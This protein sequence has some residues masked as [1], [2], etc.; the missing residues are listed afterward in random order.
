MKN[1]FNILLILVIVSS[2]LL[3]ACGDGTSGKKDDG[4]IDIHFPEEVVLTAFN[5]LDD[6]YIEKI[7]EQEGVEEASLND[8]GS[9]SLKVTKEVQGQML[10]GMIPAIDAAIKELEEIKLASK[11]T[12]SDNYSKFEIVNPDGKEYFLENAESA[13]IGLDWIGQRVVT[14]QGYAA[15]EIGIEMTVKDEN[16]ELIDT[17]NY[18][19]DFQEQINSRI[20]MLEDKK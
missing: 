6:E 8:D 11:I 18:P 17:Y 7:S 12:H 3:T 13:K 2:L 20:E 9:F 19:E 1:K 14:Y 4:L 5:S 16:G 15:E 10:E